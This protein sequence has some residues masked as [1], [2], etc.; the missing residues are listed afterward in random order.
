M[1]NPKCKFKLANIDDKTN[2]GS[3]GQRPAAQDAL[4]DGSM[5]AQGS[6]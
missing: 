1:T 5:P 3:G 4:W 6:A 2:K